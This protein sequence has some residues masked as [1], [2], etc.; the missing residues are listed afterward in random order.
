MRKKRFIFFPFA[1]PGNPNQPIPI[2][3]LR[4]L[5]FLKEVLLLSVT[6]FGGPQAHLAR[7]LKRLVQRHRYLTEEELLELQA[8]CQ[9]LP[10]P[11]STQTLTA[12]AFR[13]GGPN[14]AYLTLLIW[15]LPS[16][17]L[18]AT[19]AIGMKY[20]PDMHFARFLE[21]IAVGLVVHAGF[22]IARKVLTN[23][24]RISLALLATITAFFFQSPFITPVVVLGGGVATALEYRKLERKEQKEPMQIEW[25]NFLLFLT[26][27]IIAAIL[28]AVTHWLPVRLFENF[29]RNGSLI[30]GGGD[31]LMPV[32]LTEFVKFKQY[33][34]QEEFLSGLAM[35]RVMPGPVFGFAAFIGA[36]AMRQYSLTDQLVAAGMATAGIFLPGTFLIFFVYR[37]WD[38][39]KQYRVVRASLEGITAAGTGLI[40][41]ASIILLQSLQHTPTDYG[42]VILTFLLLQFTK[43]PQ[44]LLVVAG[45]AA[46]WVF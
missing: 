29:Y 5:I 1:Q 14:L 38:Q 40:G 11:T 34:N 46:G 18:M 4:Y 42:I 35:V 19:L 27:P 15:I 28:G 20:V 7:F 2:R 26:V 10:G 13:L 37:F 36:L 8:L 44:P 23:P 25:A 31:V 32:L 41:A 45:L 22:A 30:F 39:L 3:R 33:L 6:C 21:P 17:A 16:S 9:I 12:I 43:I 24:V